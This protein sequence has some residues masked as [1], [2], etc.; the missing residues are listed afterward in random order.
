[1]V[2]PICERTLERYALIPDRIWNGVDTVPIVNSAVV[3]EGR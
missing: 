1:M 3:I 2:N